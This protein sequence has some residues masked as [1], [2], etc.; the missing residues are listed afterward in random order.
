MSELLDIFGE[1]TSL[2]DVDIT[3]DVGGTGGLFD[4]GVYDFEIERAELKD[5]SKKTGK[6]VSVM[7]RE[8]NGRRCYFENY[9]VQNPSEI[10]QSIGRE[11]LK[12]LVK[13]LGF[14]KMPTEDELIGKQVSLALI[15]AETSASKKARQ[16]KPDTEVIMENRIRKYGAEKEEAP[17]AVN[18]NI[19]LNSTL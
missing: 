11:Q 3:A 6:F 17:K 18:T 13:S 5:T 2:D 12:L 8:V 15:Q 14:E 4:T 1:D 19:N 9:N 16:R 7:F 10:A